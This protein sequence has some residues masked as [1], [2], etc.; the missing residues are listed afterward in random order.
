MFNDNLSSHA[1]IISARANIPTDSSLRRNKLFDYR[2]ECMFYIGDII[3]I[4][5]PRVLRAT[6]WALYAFGSVFTRNA[7]GIL[8][9]ARIR[10]LSVKFHSVLTISILP[11]VAIRYIQWKG[12]FFSVILLFLRDEQRGYFSYFSFWHCPLLSLYLSLYFICCN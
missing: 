2:R 6:V 9:K 10:P 3:L 4:K 11:R 12:I 8:D 1:I 7:R 5:F